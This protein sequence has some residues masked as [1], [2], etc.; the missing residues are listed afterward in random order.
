MGQL[1]S[2]VDNTGSM[3]E[4]CTATKNSIAEITAI[5]SLIH[6]DIKNIICSIGDYDSNTPDHHQGGFSIIPNG[7]PD[8]QH[9]WL[10]KYIKAAGGGGRPE[11][12]KT[13]LNFLL[14]KFS[15]GQKKV[16][17]I[18]LDAVPHGM[19]G[20]ELD[21]EGIKELAFINKNEGMIWDW[22]KLAIE[23]K[24]QFTVFVFSTSAAQKELLKS[25]YTKLGT[26]LF[27][28]KNTTEVITKTMMTVINGLLGQPQNDDN[29]YY[30]FND[31]KKEIIE[32]KRIPFIEQI[33]FNK[34]IRE[35]HPERVC[36]IFLQILK[37]PNPASIMCLTTNTFLGKLWRLICGR[38]QFVE[39]GRYK[40]SCEQIQNFLSDKIN[41]LP[42]SQ[43]EIVKKWNLE[44]HNNLE[45][46]FDKITKIMSTGEVQKCI[47]LSEK[48]EVS[49]QDVIDLMKVGKYKDLAH[50]FPY[51]KIINAEEVPSFS[52]E[53]ILFVPIIEDN[54]LETFILL[55]NLISPGLLFSRSEA[56]FASI[57]ALSNKEL[58]GYAF[59]LLEQNK[60]K[61][62]NFELDKD[63]SQKFPLFWSLN[64]IHLLNSLPDVLL[65][66]TERLFI[67]K[68]R[69][70]ARLIQN[71]NQTIEITIPKPIND[72]S[73]VKEETNRRHCPL[74][75]QL[76]CFTM[77]PGDS[78][79]CGLCIVLDPS[80]PTYSH[81]IAISEKY[82]TASDP[83]KIYEGD[84]MAHFTQCAICTCK[85]SVA[86]IH[87]KKVRSKCHPC[88]NGLLPE[89][90]QCKLCL[91][92]YLSPGGSAYLCGS[93]SDSSRDYI[94]SPCKRSP[95]DSLST[96]TL[97]IHALIGT[98]PGLKQLFPVRMCTS[99]N[100]DYIAALASSEIS[101]KEIDDTYKY[102][103]NPSIPLW[104]KVISLIRYESKFEPI[105]LRHDG[106]P[107]HKSYNVCEQIRE[108]LSSNQATFTCNLCVSDTHIREQT[109]ACGNCNIYCCKEC[110]FRWYSDITIGTV[111]SE[112]HTKCPF[113]KRF[114]RRDIF[115][116]MISLDI[117]RLKN[118]K[119]DSRG[120]CAWDPRM[121]YASCIE[122]LHVKPF[123]QRDCS[124]DIPQIKNFVCEDCRQNKAKD[125][126][127][128]APDAPKTLECPKCKSMTFKD[129]GCNHITCRCGEHWCWGCGKGGFNSHSIYDHMIGC[130]GIG[131]VEED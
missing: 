47:I 53:S 33:D 31:H 111:I 22:D 18:I 94:C 56:F 75:N 29:T 13:G 128:S 59:K 50:L 131:L 32:T 38:Y 17:F 60:G 92:K 9:R 36:E 118:I 3:G 82:Y 97:K 103:T 76:R 113:C 93:S 45:I 16:L 34:I 81:M 35:V 74:C 49:M 4:A 95:K 26:L 6:P 68:F 40:K 1:F 62:I 46:I 14:K 125:L 42:P 15:S 79:K 30:Q 64:I 120:L 25:I 104:K 8:E 116:G 89:F 54:L 2:L 78:E 119:P 66:E 96:V 130:K 51:F 121:V 123:I 24:S 108:L 124:A 41:K 101:T 122:C 10:E 91:H 100:E 107:V 63:Q 110:I 114:P 27:I 72:D 65:L 58:G 115:K 77:F 80:S 21:T 61:W 98:N 105:E 90:V 28:S 99:D 12:Y 126:L 85:Y 106:L 67:N 84:G 102:L 5:L 52:E 7:S 19:P 20:C 11:A 71:L 70:V 57:L 112:C 109:P 44:S 129:K 87:D 88:R 117:N 55:S 69:F 48:P 23:I 86:V 39:D 37:N 73:S 83:C 127:A 43:A